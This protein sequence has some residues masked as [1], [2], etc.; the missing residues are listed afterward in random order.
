MGFEE[1]ADMLKKNASN[2]SESLA[3]FQSLASEEFMVESTDARTALIHIGKRRLGS[4]DW[5]STLWDKVLNIIMDNAPLT[6]DSEWWVQRENLFE[7]M[8]RALK[9]QKN[10]N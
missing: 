10:P 4:H 5:D 9:Q 7:R 2:E 3:T 1:F 6:V 8:L